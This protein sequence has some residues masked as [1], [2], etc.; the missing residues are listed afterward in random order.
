MH[1]L[2]LNQYSKPVG[3]L[4]TRVYYFWGEDYLSRAY[5][6]PVQP[7]TAAQRVRW[8][9][10]QRAVRAWQRLLPAEKVLY[11]ERAKPLKM[12]GFNLKVREYMLN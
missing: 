12:S 10:F 8:G 11:N 6:K 7:G 4:G 1:R 9:K 2:K 5:V 3:K